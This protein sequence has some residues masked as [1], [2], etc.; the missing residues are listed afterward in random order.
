MNSGAA[1]GAEVPGAK[2]HLSGARVKGALTCLAAQ[3]SIG[4]HARFFSTRWANNFS[5]PSAEIQLC[6]WTSRLQR[7]TRRMLCAIQP[8]PQLFG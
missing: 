4:A 1:T 2:A 3:F 7:Q 5:L 6:L 8:L